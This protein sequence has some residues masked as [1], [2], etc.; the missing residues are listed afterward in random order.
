[1]LPPCDT[2]IQA[3]RDAGL[4]EVQTLRVCVG[5]TTPTRNLVLPR[6]ALAQAYTLPSLEGAPWTAPGAGGRICIST[7]AKFTGE[8]PEA[9]D[10]GSPLSPFSKR[11]R[12]FPREPK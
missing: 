9:T 6:V 3:S 10:D 5:M 7:P 1:M 4:F 11:G 12:R 8:D 2:G